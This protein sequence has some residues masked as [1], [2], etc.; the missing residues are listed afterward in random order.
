MP[1]TA[2]IQALVN[3]GTKGIVLAGT[4]AGGLSSF[5]KAAVKTVLTLPPASQ[6]VLVR[7][8]RVGNGRVIAREDWDAMGLIPADTL[9]P[10]KARIL[11]VLA[12]TKTNDLKEIRRMFAEY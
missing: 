3:G 7:S 12:L 9:N 4:G 2:T 1:D 10:Q 6:P 11:L 5:E 8:S